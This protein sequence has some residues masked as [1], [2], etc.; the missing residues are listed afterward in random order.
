MVYAKLPEV[1]AQLSRRGLSLLVSSRHF[2]WCNSFKVIVKSLAQSPHTVAFHF[3]YL[4]TN[5]IR[6]FIK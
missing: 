6:C 1:P 5:V 3:F 4:K 2:T